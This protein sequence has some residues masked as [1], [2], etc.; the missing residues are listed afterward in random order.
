MAASSAE[1]PDSRI[2]RPTNT[3]ADILA[4]ASDSEPG[5]QLPAPPWTIREMGNEVIRA[6]KKKWM[7]GLYGARICS[8]WIYSAVENETPAWA[9]IKSHFCFKRGAGIA[10]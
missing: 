4:T 1:P 5:R 6:F 9:G 10:L 8:A 2:L 7:R 3:A